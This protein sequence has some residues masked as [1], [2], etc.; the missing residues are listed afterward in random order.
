MRPTTRKRKKKK[1]E[2]RNPGGGRVRLLITRPI[3]MAAK[4]KKEDGGDHGFFLHS[5]THSSRG[6]KRGIWE[7]GHSGKRR[8]KVGDRLADHSPRRRAGA[9]SPACAR[10]KKGK[11]PPTEPER[12]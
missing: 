7:G 6:E 2:S 10:E 12:K 3:A 4:K 1:G 11:A 9:S 8:E 5:R